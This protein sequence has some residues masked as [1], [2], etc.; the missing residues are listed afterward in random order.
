MLIINYAPLAA[1][2]LF[3]LWA[4]FA[5][6]K[7]KN[8][9]LL[10]WL[11]VAFD[12]LMAALKSIVQYWVWDQSSLTHVINNLPLKKLDLTWFGNLPIF[13]VYRHGYYLFYI[14]NNFWR[15]T[16]LTFLAA[17]IIYFIFLA[18]KKYKQ[19]LFA[20]KEAETGLLFA[21]LIGWP[22]VIF[23]LPLVFVIALIFILI[24]L[25]T[26]RGATCHLFWPFAISTAIIFIFSGY[27]DQVRYLLFK[28]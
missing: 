19:K 18:L 12:I 2:A 3:F 1:M 16:F 4:L 22:Q 5:F 28:F 23:F 20:D 11:L 17:F 8:F 15:T 9:W 27:F 25:I 10:V 14:W 7:K 26:K 13:T 21:L 6:W 24:N